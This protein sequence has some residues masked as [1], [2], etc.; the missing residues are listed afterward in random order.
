MGNDGPPGMEDM[1]EEV[2]EQGNGGRLRLGRDR[3][4]GGVA[5]LPGGVRVGGAYGGVPGLPVLSLRRQVST[6]KDFWEEWTSNLLQ[7]HR[8]SQYKISRWMPSSRENNTRACVWKKKKFPIL[9]MIAQVISQDPD[10]R[11]PPGHHA[12]E[13]FTHTHLMRMEPPFPPFVL[14]AVN[15]VQEF[16]DRLNLETV[17]PLC[18]RWRSNRGNGYNRGANF[19]IRQFLST[20]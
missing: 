19:S 8:R 7:Y 14:D 4:G 1:K 5:V 20:N 3:E 18:N 15:K 17:D 16:Q 11:R 6:V 9:Q 12:Q 2:E 10:N 13:P